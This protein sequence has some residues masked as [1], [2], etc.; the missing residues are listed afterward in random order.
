MAKYVCDF[1][2]VQSVGKNICDAASEME[3]SVSTYSS[4][5]DGDL[6]GWNGAA[7]DSFNTTNTEQVAQATS[8]A[9]SMNELGNFIQDAAQSIQS[10]D[11]E[12]AS[13]SI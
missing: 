2:Q 1:D 8:N 12:L 4:N 7:K 13:M 10:L 3:T 5:I 9:Q 6:S 11:S